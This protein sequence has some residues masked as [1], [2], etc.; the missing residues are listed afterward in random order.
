MFWFKARS[1]SFIIGVFGLAPSFFLNACKP[2]VKS[3]GLFDLKGYFM[4]DTARLNRSATT[5]FKTVTH[6]GVTES[7]KVRI[8]DWGKELSLFIDADIN[9]AA[10]KNSYK[11]ISEDSLLVYRARDKDLKVR[12]LIIKRD[13]QKVKYI[14]IY[15]KTEN[16]LYTTTQKLSYFPDSLYMIETV[17]RVRLIGTNF[18]RIRGVIV[19]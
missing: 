18:Y 10:W 13:K 6:N 1:R 17:Q 2:E 12:E 11:V 4:Q 9:K 15:N 14:L 7:K 3:N 5:V 19:K 16:I 8:G